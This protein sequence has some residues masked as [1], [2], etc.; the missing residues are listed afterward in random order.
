MVCDGTVMYKI[1]IASF[2]NGARNT[3]ASKSVPVTLVGMHVE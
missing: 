1:Q 2:G 3:S